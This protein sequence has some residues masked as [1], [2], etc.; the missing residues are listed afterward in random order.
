MMT[1]KYKKLR[2][3][4][5]VFTFLWTS[6]LPLFGEDGKWVIAAQKFIYARGQ[7]K[8]AVTSNIEETIPINILEKISRS[9]ERNIMPNERFERENYKLRTERQSLYLQ[10]SSEYKKR[11]SLVLNNYS[12]MRM[13]SE[14]KAEEKKIKQIQEKL[15][16]NIAEQKEK[17]EKAEAQMHLA[18]GEV[19]DDDNVELNEAEL[20]KNLIK[21]IFEQSE[22]LITEENIALYKDSVESLFKTTVKVKETDYTEPLFEKEVV[23]SGINGLITGQITSY[24][25][26]ISVAVDLYN[27]PGAKKI[28]SVMEV[29]ESK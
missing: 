16:K 20:V 26:F 19:D 22:D 25:D 8:N 28:G 29:S 21:N 23:S 15:E 18:A 14:L 17:Y 5:L 9:L 1:K 13:K 27:Y 6:F 10:L 11:D 4:V 12:D 3:V 24:G 7:T 2:A